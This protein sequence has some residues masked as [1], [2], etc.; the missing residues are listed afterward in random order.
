MKEEFW[1]QFT[2][3]EILDM[4]LPDKHLDILLTEVENLYFDYADLLK[5]DVELKMVNGK[6]PVR[7]RLEEFER[8]VN[9]MW[10]LVLH[11]YGKKHV[12]DLPR[13][14]YHDVCKYI[15]CK[16][17]QLIKEFMHL[18]YRWVLLT[19]EYKPKYN[20]YIVGIV[21][22]LKKYNILGYEEKNE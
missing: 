1:K 17:N 22:L 8:D 15:S 10:S 20:P 14:V 5:C 7:I 2:E 18:A 11:K 13:Q 19:D 12:Y 9:A 4:V 21:C 16:G 3:E 6:S